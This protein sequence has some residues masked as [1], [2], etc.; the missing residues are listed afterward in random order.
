MLETMRSDFGSG[1]SGLTDGTLKKVV[2]EL[3]GLKTVVVDG[4]AADT[5]IAV[6]GLAAND[7]IQSCV[8]FAAGVPSSLAVSAQS[9]GFIQFASVT[10]GNKIVVSYYDRA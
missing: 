7:H 6:A 9:A 2:K 5:N 3:R 1:G 10:T 4:A 8:M